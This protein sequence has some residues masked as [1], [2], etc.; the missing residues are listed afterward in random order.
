MQL[1]IY[2]KELY[3]QLYKEICAQY[4]RV[5]SII[6]KHWKKYPKIDGQINYSNFM[7]WSVGSL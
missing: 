5:L 1:E 2:P 6:A 7:Q 4:M 3:E